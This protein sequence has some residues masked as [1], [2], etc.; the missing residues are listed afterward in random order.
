MDIL[1]C[2]VVETGTKVWLP[3][4]E[5]ERFAALGRVRLPAPKPDARYAAPRP[6]PLASTWREGRFWP[7]NFMTRDGSQ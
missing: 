7:A 5:A 6:L 4:V 3:R 1:E 2:E